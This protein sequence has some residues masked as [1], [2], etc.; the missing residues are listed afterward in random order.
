M[1]KEHLAIRKIQVKLLMK[2]SP[3]LRMFNIK[4]TRGNKCWSS[5]W[6]RGTLIHIMWVGVQTSAVT[7]EIYLEDS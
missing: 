6:D 7:V 4:E 3:S 5:G 1:I 2:S